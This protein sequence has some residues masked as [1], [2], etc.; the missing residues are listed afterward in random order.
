L[1]QQRNAFFEKYGL[2]LIIS[3]IFLGTAMITFH[4]RLYG[5]DF[6][7]A[8]F[9]SHNL[10]YFI[11]KHIEHY[12]RANGRVIVHLLATIFLGIPLTFWQILNPLML[13][14]IAY[15]GSKIAQIKKDPSS[16]YSTKNLYAAIIFGIGIAFLHPNITRQSVYWLTGSFNYVYPILLLFIYWYK[17]SLCIYQHHW[18]W[19]LPFWAFFASATV[20]QVSLMSFGLTLCLLLEQ[21]ILQKEKIN[22]IQKIT[23][24]LSTIGMLTV[25]AAPGVF[26]RTSIEKTPVTGFFNLLKHNIKTQGNSFL[27][28]E[29]MVPY[30]ILAMTTS[31]GTIINYG[32]Q[33]YTT[34][35][36]RITKQ[37]KWLH[38]TILLIGSSAC[39]SWLWQV[40]VRSSMTNYN[41]WT[42]K[43]F[44][45][46]LFITIGYLITLLYTT[47]ITY[48][49]KIIIN[50]TVPI[51]SVILCFGSQ[52]MMII[53]P[54]YGPRNLVC[55]IFML[56]LYIATL[57][58]TLHHIGIP[59]LIAL[60]AC[61]ALHKPLFF[62]FAIGTILLVSQPLIFVNK[63][64][65][66]KIG[67][68]GGY[69][70]LTILSWYTFVPTIKGYAKNSVIYDQNIKI[71][72]QYK[73]KQALHPNPKSLIQSTL[74]IE[75]YG[76]AMPYH[77]PYYDPY[78]RLYLGVDT[79]T[80]IQ[81]VNN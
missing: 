32:Y 15:F 39:M 21:K 27:F 18:T 45:F 53:S 74:P 63:T 49:E 72:R 71:A 36:Q 54:V 7:Y 59:N 13:A 52:L 44:L 69:I 35:N 31:L 68:I 62:P 46:Y 76:W 10:S 19:S 16:T 81:W 64:F 50:Y 60:I 24:F 51:I 8:Q 43:Q 67:T 40:T 3:L 5:D 34:K 26:L 6:F 61:F 79:K 75:L 65:F 17:L 2:L 38:D 73:T 25:I 56:L 80:S 28:S 57:L 77:N 12:F 22:T 33:Y 41:I 48:Q 30:H 55:A 66:K 9:T 37:R 42:K 1:K 11:S 70:I 78:Y 29:M 20:E 23:L 47:M 58:P 4:V 14:G